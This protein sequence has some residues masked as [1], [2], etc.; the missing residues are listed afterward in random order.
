MKATEAAP[1]KGPA[2]VPGHQVL[3]EGLVADIL[4]EHFGEA[5]ELVGL[6]LFRNG[7]LAFSDI[8]RICNL[9]FLAFPRDAVNLYNE[10][11]QAT[12]ASDSISFRS[13]RDALL[14]LIH[15]GLVTVTQG[16][17]TLYAL[18]AV[19][20]VGRL[21]LPVYLDLFSDEEERAVLEHVL[22]RSLVS[23]TRLI[24]LVGTRSA[25]E[26]V[27]N[28]I[29]RRVLVT[30]ESMVTA[31]AS[32]DKAAD[33]ASADV[34]LRF[35]STELQLSVI[36][37]YV[38]D[39]V[40]AKHDALSAS[41]VEQLLTAV[42][43]VGSVDSR[44]F[45][46]RISVGELAISDIAK[47]LPKTSSNDLIATLIK[48]QQHNIVAKKQFTAAA[49]TAP[50]TAA[51]RKRKTPSKPTRAANTKQLL[52]MAE[53]DSGEESY[54]S[55]LLATDGAPSYSLKFRDVIEE[56]G[57]DIVFNLVKAKYGVD[58]ARVFELLSSS[59]QKFEASHVADL[60]AISRED[61]LKHLHGFAS[62]GL[63]QIQEVPKV[64]SSSAAASGGL[65]AMMRAVASSFWLYYV[66]EEKVR[67]ALVSLLANSVVNLRRRFRFE[68]NRQCKIEDR[69][70]VLTKAE[71]EY[72]ESVH[73]AQDLLEA[74]SIQLV[75]SLMILLIRA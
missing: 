7:Q 67:R 16:S 55:N 19:E 40:G 58:A 26:T 15:H 35:N 73:S 65:A 14:V 25:K 27:S 45:A 32:N 33:Q 48:L 43:S 70:S 64:V 75:F 13:V 4:N 61:A 53:E 41:V 56:I 20:I 24:E 66:E 63:C 59:R 6:V 21:F 38:A 60:C 44:S 47:Y 1:P 29:N 74:N 11:S 52:A 8:V 22:K 17:P 28:L 46:S 42:I 37:Q 5:V 30:A 3:L 36:K 23:R 57:T 49:Q 18:N 68:V 10:Y 51:G 9:S 71:Q 12:F 2:S 69:A 31:V 34:A 72:L 50:T 39:F 54:F 62:D